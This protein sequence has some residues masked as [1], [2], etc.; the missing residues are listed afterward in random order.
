MP[1]LLTGNTVNRFKRAVKLKFNHPN[2]VDPIELINK[3]NRWYL[4]MPYV[5]GQTLDKY[6]LAHGGK[7]SPD[8]S[9]S[10]IK[11]IANAIKRIDQYGCVHGISSLQT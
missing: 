1:L 8:K 6:V 4:T 11:Q 10:I 5:E 3:N 7:L 9:T 2:I